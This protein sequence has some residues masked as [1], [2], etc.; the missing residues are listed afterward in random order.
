MKSGTRFTCFPGTKLQI[1]TP[2]E[3][4]VSLLR[5]LKHRHVVQYIGTHQRDDSLNILMEFCPGGSVAS[6]LSVP[7]FVK[8]SQYLFKALWQCLFKALSLRSCHYLFK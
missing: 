5:S 4:R 7:F 3:L 8:K 1:L 6:L 2:Q